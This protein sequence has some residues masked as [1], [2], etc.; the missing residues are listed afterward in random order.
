MFETIEMPQRLFG[1]N[2]PILMLI[3]WIYATH[4]NNAEHHKAQ[5]VMACWGMLTALWILIIIL[6]FSLLNMCP[7]ANYV[8]V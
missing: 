6:S 3:L 1:N 7:R 5:V 2:C 4:L 8:Q